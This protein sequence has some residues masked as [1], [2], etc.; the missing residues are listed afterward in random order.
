[1][2][3]RLYTFKRMPIKIV[4]LQK[5]S[6][7]GCNHFSSSRLSNENYSTVFK[8]PF[9]CMS[10][11]PHCEVPRRAGSPINCSDAAASPRNDAHQLIFSLETFVSTHQTFDSL[12]FRP[13]F[14]LSAPKKVLQEERN[15]NRLRPAA[16]AER[17]TV[18]NCSA[19][20]C[21]FLQSGLQ[22]L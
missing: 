5:T 9:Y 13:V 17:I 15:T 22:I 18:N 8:A 21:N 19:T 16:G 6:L 14:F 1:M 12:I 11:T 2:K 4:W 7:Y 20:N 10:H 3:H